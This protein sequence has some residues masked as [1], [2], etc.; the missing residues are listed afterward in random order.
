MSRKKRKMPSLKN[1]KHI[2]LNDLAEPSLPGGDGVHLDS[3]HLLQPYPQVA[4]QDGP[5]L[6]RLR[7]YQ[8]TLS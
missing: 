5:A 1:G 7:T 6:F 8:L 3:V 2:F 4:L